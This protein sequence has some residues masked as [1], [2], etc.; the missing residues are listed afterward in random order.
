MSQQ[1]NAGEDQGGS[2]Q[3]V[4]P[5]DDDAK[6]ILEK[7]KLTGGESPSFGQDGATYTGEQRDA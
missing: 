4:K 1:P 5:L 6:R 2:A 7:S 3:E